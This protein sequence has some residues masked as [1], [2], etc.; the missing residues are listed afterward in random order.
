VLKEEDLAARIAGEKALAEVPAPVPPAAPPPAGSS[1]SSPLASDFRPNPALVRM[2]IIATGLLVLMLI[3]FVLTSMLQA[4]FPFLAYVRAFAEAATVGASADWFAVVALFRHPLG[5]PIPHTAIVPRSKQRIGEALGR[6]IANNFLAPEVISAKLDRFDAAGWLAR[7]LSEPGHAA[8]VARRSTGAMPLMLDLM[9]HDRFREFARR[10][11]RK[12]VDSLAAAPMAARTLT[13]LVSRNHDQDLFDLGLQLSEKF[14]EENREMLRAKVSEHS[15]SWLPEWIDL[16]LADMVLGGLGKTLADL[17][18][19]DHSYRVEVRAAVE[20]LIQRLKEDPEMYERCEQ[21]KA[22]VL[23]SAVVES[24]LQWLSDEIQNWIKSDT[25]AQESVVMG[26]LE[27][28]L[29][30]I[31]KWLSEDQATRARVNRWLRDAVLDTVVPNRNEIS[32]FI[33]EE[34]ARWDAR[35]LVVRAENQLGKDLQFIRI[36]GTV[37]GGLVGLLIF[38]TERLLA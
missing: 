35:T 3:V 23:D 29:L 34:V 4:R 19:P 13:V 11:V 1:L 12:G 36:N 15:V 24:Y 33:A 18:R 25:E 30:A 2:R 21:V 26:G 7:W 17:H 14:L 5:I 16:K 6:F 27:H 28:M 31:G 32:T 9:G 8:T 22:K 38:T 20:R 10:T 37:V